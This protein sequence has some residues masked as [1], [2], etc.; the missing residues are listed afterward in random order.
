[1]RIEIEKDKSYT[2]SWSFYDHNIQDIPVSGNITV[3]KPSGTELVANTPVTVETDG[4]IKYTLDSSL[5][6]SIEPNYKIEL[7]YQVGD[8]KTRPYYLFDIVA[9][10]LINTVRDE[11]LFQYVEELRD[12]NTPFVKETTDTGTVN[13]FFSTDL[14]SL[15][16]DFK[17]GSVEIYIDDTTVHYAEITAWDS[18]LDKVTFTP[19]YTSGIDTAKRFRIRGSYQRFIDEAYINTVSR[20]IRNRIKYKARFID[21]TVTRN[22]TIYKALELICFSKV[23]EID[24]KWDIRAK[25]FK[26]EYTSEYTK[27]SE[28]VDLDDDGNI[29]PSEDEN[30]PNFLN[31]SLIR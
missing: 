19:A 5:T 22:M 4:E 27:L 11:D 12:K 6:G 28:P 24:D 20:D 14:A 31:K 3:Y 9:T 26:D 10:P 1:M 18:S 7:E 8:V 29:S 21:T 25:R 23:E 2:F 17:G 13:T 30:R 16:I 15:N